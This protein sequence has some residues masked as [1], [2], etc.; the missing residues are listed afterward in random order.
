MSGTATTIMVKLT[1]SE[2]DLLRAELAAAAE[3]L[4]AAYG[5]PI[6]G[7]QERHEARENEARVRDLLAKLG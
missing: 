7:T 6:T 3:R 1:P 5:D 4:R 2:F